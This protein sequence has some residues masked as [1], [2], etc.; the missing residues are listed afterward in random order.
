MRRRTEFEK[1]V[2]RLTP[3]SPSPRF[4][5]TFDLLWSQVR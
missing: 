1:D 2:R 3:A 5:R 4:S